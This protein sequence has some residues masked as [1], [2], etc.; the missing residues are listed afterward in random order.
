MFKKIV[1]VCGV[2][3][4]FMTAC[5]SD[6][7]S[8]A[9]VD[10][11]ETAAPTAVATAEP[12][13][14]AKANGGLEDVFQPLSLMGAPL[15]GG[16]GGGDGSDMQVG[17]QNVDPELKAVLLTAED[18]PPGY[19]GLGGDIGYSMDMPEGSVSMAARMFAEGDVMSGEPG[20]IVMSAVM[21]MPASALDEFDASIAK[22]ENMDLSPEGIAKM[23]G[24]SGVQGIEFKEF[25]LIKDPGL[26]EAGVGM[27]MVMDMSG[28]A[29]GLGAEM[30]AY[31]NG[32]AMDVYMFT[33][34]ERVLMLMVM[35]PAGGQ[36]SVDGLALAEIMDGRAQ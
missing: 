11:D 14:E 29:G 17:S 26:G 16:A 1:I 13:K 12:T 6:K 30:G 31:E 20:S 3:L 24:E 23:V 8:S 5:G 7:D 21:A 19:N 32:I 2:L 27:H 34:G 10:K 22:L 35:W 33:R 25:Q 28:A 4:L 18:L 15:F 9:P 36:P